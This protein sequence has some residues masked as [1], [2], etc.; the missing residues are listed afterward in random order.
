M[1]AD[2]SGAA[3]VNLNDSGLLEDAVSADGQD[4]LVPRGDDLA[5]LKRYIREQLG[6]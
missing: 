2:P 1:R 3:R 5:P 6:E 4:I